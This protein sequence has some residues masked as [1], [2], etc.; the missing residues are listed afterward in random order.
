[1]ASRKRPK[2]T[3]NTVRLEANLL[4]RIERI[5]AK[6][7]MTTKECVNGALWAMV[8]RYESAGACSD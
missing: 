6:H 7:D 8:W 1:M 2:A 4:K 5:C 3:G